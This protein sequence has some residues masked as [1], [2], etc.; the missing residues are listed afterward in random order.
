METPRGLTL[1]FQHLLPFLADFFL[2]LGARLRDRRKILDP[3]ERPARVDDRARVEALLPGLDARIERPAPAATENLNRLRRIGA[4]RERPEDVESAGRIDVFIHDN[5][6]AAEIGARVDLRRSE[7]R[8]ARVA[9]IALFDRDDVEEPA[10]AGFVAPY[11][12]HVRNAGLFHLLPD[13]SGFH[14]ALRDGI[15]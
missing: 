7:H 2:E 1:P 5:D 13:E 9:G 4:R 14:H 10:A 12:A 11:A 8:L 6:V 3:L 15:I